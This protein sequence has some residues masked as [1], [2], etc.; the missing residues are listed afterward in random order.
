M[1]KYLPI[2]L[3]I[4]GIGLPMYYTGKYSKPQH[5]LKQTILK[6]KDIPQELWFHYFTRKGLNKWLECEDFK[7]KDIKDIK[8]LEYKYEDFIGKIKAKLT[9][10]NKDLLYCFYIVKNPDVRAKSRWVISDLYKDK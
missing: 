2:L 7:A 8:I 3:V 9:L 6:L 1:E 10:S 5:V 4:F